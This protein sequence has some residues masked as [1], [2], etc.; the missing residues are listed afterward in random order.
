MLKRRAAI[1][2]TE[3]APKTFDKYSN[4]IGDWS[5]EGFD[6]WTR[7]DFPATTLAVRARPGWLSGLRVSH[8]K[9][10]LFGAFVR[11]CKALDGPKRRFSARAGWQALGRGARLRLLGLL[12]GRAGRRDQPDVQRQVHRPGALGR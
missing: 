2:A 9:S 1:K 12:R 5:Y 8:S 4:G 6:S 3:G 11:A 10:V 7:F